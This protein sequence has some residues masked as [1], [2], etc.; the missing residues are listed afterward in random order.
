MKKT[1]TT[2]L[3]T[4]VLLSVYNVSSQTLSGDFV[5]ANAWVK[6]N[7]EWSNMLYYTEIP[8][9]LNSS[10]RFKITSYDFLSVFVEGKISLANLNGYDYAEM[11]N[12]KYVETQTNKGKKFIIY[13]GNLQFGSRDPTRSSLPVKFAFWI[14]DNKIS[15]LQIQIKDNPRTHLLK[16][17]SKIKHEK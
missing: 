9:T 5:V 2:L 17:T 3:F 14:E 16:L 1:L 8:V 11:K 6:E 10:G 12:P 7:D 13:E 15:S 4:A